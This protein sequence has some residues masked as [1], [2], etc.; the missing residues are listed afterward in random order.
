MNTVI[1]FFHYYTSTACKVINSYS[2]NTKHV[3]SFVSLCLNGDTLLHIG[4]E[5]MYKVYLQQQKAKYNVELLSLT[6]LNLIGKYA[7]KIC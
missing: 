2:L 4:H 7:L 6:Y 3:A 1:C 5:H